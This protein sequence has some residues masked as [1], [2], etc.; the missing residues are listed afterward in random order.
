M[1]TE[2]ISEQA[3]VQATA[4]GPARPGDSEPVP[5]PPAGLPLPTGPEPGDEAVASPPGVRSPGR[6]PGSPSAAG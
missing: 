5:D 2:R 6:S 1:S 4:A 3:A